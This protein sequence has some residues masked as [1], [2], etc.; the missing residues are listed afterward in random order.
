MGW[1]D[2]LNEEKK[3]LV[4]PW[5]GGRVLYGQGRSW[6]MKGNLPEEYGWYK[7]QEKGGRNIVSKGEIEE[8]FG[9]EEE[10]PK[11]LFGYLV[12]SRLI[13]DASWVVPDPDKIIEQTKDVCLVDPGLDRFSRAMVVHYEQQHYVYARP[14]FPI[15]PEAEVLEA[16]LNR[17]DSVA[18]IKG[19]TPALDL[20]FQ[21]ESL[22]RTKQEERRRLAEQK[23]REE[24]EQR[25][26]EQRREQFMRQIGTG[27][28]R[29]LLAQVD[30]GAAAEAALQV[31]G[32][33]LL[34]ARPSYRATEMVVQFRYEERRLE[35][36]VE[37]A[38]LHVID[39][40]ICLQGHDQLFT[41]ESLPPV[42]SNAIRERRLHVFRR[43]KESFSNGL[44]EKRILEREGM[45][46]W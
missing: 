46:G 42:I 1:E 21:F 11:K 2:F 34:D 12:G 15:G 5:L 38:T 44:E 40:G 10:Q 28:G 41:L 18:E 35:C 14:E 33:V 7:F 9:W 29:R 6:R 22:M 31:S 45:G 4:L 36:V 26:Q 8:P 17:A 16:F 32:A 30:F 27:E 43:G 23:A 3:E 25:E 37:K 19:V 13:P 20:A 24:Q 39:A